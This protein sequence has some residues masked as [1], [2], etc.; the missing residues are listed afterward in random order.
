[1]TPG[2]IGQAFARLAEQQPDAVAVRC[3]G[4]VVTRAEL[5]SATNRIA[6]GWVADGVGPDDVVAVALPS[7]LDAVLA[8]VAVW[9]AGASLLPISPGLSRVEREPLLALAE[10]ALLVDSSDG[11]EVSAEASSDDTPLPPLA[12]SSWKSSSS[13]GSTGPPKLIRAAA[14]ARIDP[15]GP[16]VPWVPHAAVQLVAG[17]LWH[18]APFVYAMRGLMTGHE[19]VV[20]P[21]FDPATWLRLV[22]R[23]RV[24]WG[25]LV[26]AMMQRILEVPDRVASDVSS[27]VSVLHLGARCA[28]WLKRDWIDWLGPERVVELYAGTEAQGLVMVGGA[29]WLTRPGTVGRPVGDTELR[30]VR[31]DGTDCDAGEIGEVLMRR[32]R[33]TYSYVGAEPSVRDGWHTLGDAGHLDADGWLFLADR[34]ADAIE[35][36]AGT[37]HPADIEAVLDEH[38]GVRT[39]VVVERAGGVHAVVETDIAAEAELIAWATARLEP[40]SL[41]TTWQFVSEPLRDAAGKVRR[42]HWRSG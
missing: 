12:A 34:L 35:T 25:L 24:T 17:P 6:R 18:S 14:A 38:P 33:P 27:L 23:H 7:G 3:A 1:M 13:S 26:P 42:S 36:A 28:P 8:Y 39:S 30:V 5:E 10:P 22:E 29:D 41:P 16:F 20:M 19:L 31:P 15:D 40:A 37:L 11:W 32:G 4:E 9:K 21:R 2:T